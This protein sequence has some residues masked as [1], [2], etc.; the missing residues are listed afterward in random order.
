MLS[1]QCSHPRPAAQLDLTAFRGNRSFTQGATLEMD[2]E[3]K[4]GAVMRATGRACLADTAVLSVNALQGAPGLAAGQLV[5]EAGGWD[6]ARELLNQRLNAANEHDGTVDR[7][8]EYIC[9]M[10]W[11]LPDGRSATVRDLLSGKIV[12]PPRFGDDQRGTGFDSIFIPE[13][14]GAPPAHSHP[15]RSTP[16]AA[17][18]DSCQSLQEKS[19]ELKTLWQ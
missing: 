5:R 12:W 8:A 9:T 17:S 14:E 19:F 18:G 3:A 10:C 13:G 16:F 11:V 2:A 4:A 1:A 7:R 6:G 15:P